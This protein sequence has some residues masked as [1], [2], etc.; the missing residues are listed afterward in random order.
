MLIVE[1]SHARIKI[2]NGTWIINLMRILCI[3]NVWLCNRTLILL[4][5]LILMILFLW[6]LI[7]CCIFCGRFS[8]QL[9]L[10]IFMMLIYLLMVLK[11]VRVRWLSRPFEIEVIG[12]ALCGLSKLYKLF[13]IARFIMC[14]HLV[15]WFLLLLI[16]VRPL[17]TYMSHNIVWWPFRVKFFQLFSVFLTEVYVGWKWFFRS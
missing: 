12:M 17:R 7:V 8:M 16:H 5:A 13:V 14:R 4:L 9:I 10:I 1:A 3:Y 15:I 11:I 2:S 6:G